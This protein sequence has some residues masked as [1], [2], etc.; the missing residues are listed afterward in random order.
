MFS[1]YWSRTGHTEFCDR[2]DHSFGS[3]L[4]DTDADAEK[5]RSP[6]R[7]RLLLF[8]IPP[9]HLLVISSWLRFSVCI[10]RSPLISSFA[11]ISMLCPP[12][13]RVLLV[14]VCTCCLAESRSGEWHWLCLPEKSPAGDFVLFFDHLLAE[15]GRPTFS[16]AITSSGFYQSNKFSI[17]DLGVRSAV[18]IPIST[19]YLLSLLYLYI[20]APDL[21]LVFELPGNTLADR[22]PDDFGITHTS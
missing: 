18:V 7:V 12:T 22:L 11:Q 19:I 10:L 16:L 21:W 14:S 8:E 2:S 17:P 6:S 13:Y 1:Y 9:F 20:C 3:T 5:P 15:T 4:P